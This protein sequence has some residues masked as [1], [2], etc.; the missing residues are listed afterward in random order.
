MPATKGDISFNV[1]VD[2]GEGPGEVAKGMP[3]PMEIDGSPLTVTVMDA[4]PG[5]GEVSIKQKDGKV[6][7]GSTGNEITITYMAEGEIGEDKK[8]TVVVPDGW[9]APLNEA[10]A[11]GKLG[12]YTVAHNKL[13]ADGTFA[14]GDA[15]TAQAPEKA[16]GAATDAVAMIMVAQVASGKKVM[17]GDTIVFT[18]TNATAPTTLGPA[19]FTTSY[20]GMQV[21]SDE[22]VKVIVQSAEG[23]TKIAVESDDSFIIDNNGTL[24]VTV[25]LKAADDSDAT[26]STDT[27]VS[28]T[29]SSGEIKPSSVTIPTGKYMA[30][31]TYSATASAYV[32]ITASATGLEDGTTEEIHADT[33]M[34]SVTSIEVTPLNAKVGTTVTIKAMATAAQ[35]P[36]VS[37]GSILNNR[38]MTEDPRGSGSY[39]ATYDVADGADGEYDVTVSI[40]ENRTDDDLTGADKLTIDSVKPKVTA[41]SPE[42][43]FKNTSEV[44]IPIMADDGT[45]SGLKS[46]MADV[47]QLDTSQTDD[48]EVMADDAGAYT[49]MVTVNADDGDQ[50]VTVT[51]TDN[52]GNSAEAT[53]TVN[54]DNTKPT[55]TAPSVDPSNVMANDE[56]TIS[57]TVVG[58]EEVLADASELNAD[59][60]MLKLTSTDGMSYT[61]KV[62]VTAE[63]NEPMVT[64]T[65]TATDAADNEADPKTVMVTLDNAAPMIT[66]A[67]AVDA[68]VA[69]K[70]HVKSGNK[71][72]ISAMLSEAATVTA[73]ASGLDAGSAALALTDAD[74]DGAGMMYTGEVTVSADGD[75]EV[76]ITI[77]ATD[78]AGNEAVPETLTVTLDN[79][80]PTVTN[81]SITPSRARN[82]HASTITADVIEAAIE[83]VS[84]DIAELYD[85]Q[86]RTEV[87]SLS[88]EDGDGTYT[89]SH[90]IR[91][92]NEA[93]NGTK[94]VTVTATDKAG[95]SGSGVGTVDLINTIDYTS[96][97]PQGISLFHVPIAVTAIDGNDAKLEKV[98]NLYDALGDAVNYLITRDN[99]TW[100]SYLGRERSSAASDV[101]ITPDLGIVAVMNSAKTLTFTG[102]AWGEGASM[103]NLK[104]DLNLIG[105]P[106]NDPRVTNISDIKELPAFKG[107]ISSIIVSSDGGFTMADGPVMG[108]AAYLIQAS[109]AASQAVSGEGWS[110]GEMAGAAP[111]ALLGQ[112]VDSQTAALFVEGALVDELTGLAKEGF[113]IKVKNLSTKSALSTVSQTDVAQWLQYDLCG[114]KSRQCSTDWR[115]LRD[116]R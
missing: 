54:V 91:E 107:K 105:L 25:K 80:A 114:H 4:K 76:T 102:N 56:V 112:K 40:D 38:V 23:A 59:A 62:M 79:T 58:A 22:D 100:N 82:G 36:T 19:V 89:G 35:E 39:S 95:N 49:L 63:G 41:T 103:I 34:A 42:G 18:Y 74:G 88:D 71:V 113:R 109:A 70:T 55:I 26:R 101:P 60:S 92:N 8:I 86:P 11:D 87:M 10:A 85:K 1:A 98:S 52:A 110:N 3:K 32:I 111:V 81:V 94:T 106:V 77:T 20:D 90:T 73:N 83:R 50:T 28:L 116:F 108:D 61:G 44:K 33:N 53:V 14:T 99:G 21:G 7:S 67:S 84:A 51:A 75:A 78:D 115:C 9:S 48:I 46:V 57:A 27:V 72:K 16:A 29:A 31:A 96:T 43:S 104:Q 5:S 24:E 66:A 12:T 2:G 69:D 93:A 97:I 37:I 30:T 13:A 65:I 15:V 6:D 47:S 45:G 68:A 64:I 17:A